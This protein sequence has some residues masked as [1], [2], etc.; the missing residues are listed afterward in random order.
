MYLQKEKP[1]CGMKN[2]RWKTPEELGH[3]EKSVCYGVG[4]LQNATNGIDMEGS[5]RDREKQNCIS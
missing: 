4:L 1:E 5:V 3:V 2:R